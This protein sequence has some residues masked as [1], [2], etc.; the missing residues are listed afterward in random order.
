MVTISFADAV[1]VK[2]NRVLA[3]T[4]KG[5]RSDMSAP[6]DRHG[7]G[8]ERAPQ[9]KEQ[10]TTLAASLAGCAAR[11][12]VKR[13]QRELRAGLVSFEKYLPDAD[14]VRIWGR[15]HAARR[16][17]EARARSGVV[18]EPEHAGT[19]HGREPGDLTHVWK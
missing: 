8:D 19:F 11:G 1:R 18:R 13:R 2:P 17:R 10:R 5:T 16:Q 4:I 7:I 14:L 3:T 6:G 15:P 9:R 12:I